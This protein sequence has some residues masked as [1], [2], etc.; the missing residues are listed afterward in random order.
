VCVGP[1]GTEK[2]ATCQFTC[3]SSTIPFHRGD[4]DANGNYNITDPVRT[5]NY[6][7]LGADA[8]PCLDAAD[9]DDN[10]DLNITDPVRS[11]NYL[12]LGGPPPAPPGPIPEPCGP[13]A[14]AELGCVEYSGC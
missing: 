1:D 4:A 5:L 11:L 6:L 10:G 14:G 8:P 3:G 12:F 2:Q 7:F 13:D 9:T